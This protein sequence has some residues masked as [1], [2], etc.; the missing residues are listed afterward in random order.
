MSGISGAQASSS[1]VD[2]VAEGLAVCLPVLNRAVKRHLDGALPFPKPP[3]RQLAL[4]HYV[5]ENDGATVQSAADALRMMPNNVSALV[6]R[7]TAAGALERWQDEGDKR[8][9]HLRVTAEA[10][11]RIGEVDS[12][13]TQRISAALQTLTEGDLGALGSALGALVALTDALR[14]D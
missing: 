9:A 3:E 11:Q 8:V 7:L 2:R 14:D 1:S 10:R 5:A 12:L 13:V 4:L 6:T